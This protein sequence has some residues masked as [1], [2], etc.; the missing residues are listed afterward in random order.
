[1]TP[2]R[3]PRLTGAPVRP[4]DARFLAALFGDAGVAAASEQAGRPWTLARARTRASGFAAHWTAH[5]FGLRVWRDDR[6]PAVLAGL[7]YCIIAGRAEVELSFAVAPDR[8][9]LGLGREAAAAALAEAPALTAGVAAVTFEANAP[10]RALLRSLG[11]RPEGAV[12]TG[13]LRLRWTP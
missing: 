8:Q 10:A 6:G 9:G 13:R 11:F 5:G 3:T 12:Q 1:M 7:Q 2:L 4:A